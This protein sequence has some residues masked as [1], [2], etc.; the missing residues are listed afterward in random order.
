MGVHLR[1]GEKH[2]CYPILHWALHRLPSLQKRA[3]LAKYLVPEPIPQEFMSVSAARA[4]LLA[5][6]SP[7]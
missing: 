4:R 1:D 5:L 2:V 3:Y 6:P 7:S